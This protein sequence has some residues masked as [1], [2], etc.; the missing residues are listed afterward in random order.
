MAFTIDLKGKVVL[1]TGG[2]SGIGLGASKQFAEAGATLIACAE[3]A[4]EEDI[5]VSFLAEMVPY[6]QRTYYYEADVS[7]KTAIKKLAMLLFQEHGRL[8]IL[9]SN[10]G[11]NVFKGLDHCTLEDWNRN[12]VLNLASH[13]LLEQSLK[14][15]LAQ[16]T[17]GVIIVMAS[18]HAYASIP[19]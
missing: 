14:P 3:L 18:N 16:A 19:G 7:K 9:V 5:V 10:A 8:D 11:Q 4:A 1:I 2:I 6:Q 15:L 12:S 17:P 13:W